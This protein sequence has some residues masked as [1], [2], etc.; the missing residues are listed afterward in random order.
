MC[1]EEGR[2]RDKKGENKVRQLWKEKM[3]IK[4]IRSSD[5]ELHWKPSG[6]Q[7]AGKN[8]S[9]AGAGVRKRELPREGNIRAEEEGGM[10]PGK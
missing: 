1:R 2:D 6:G 5:R 3:D 9:R 8:K 4:G 7:K 10:R